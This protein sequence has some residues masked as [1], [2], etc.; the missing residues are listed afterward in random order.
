MEERT[1]WGSSRQPHYALLVARR[2]CSCDVPGLKKIILFLY[3]LVL[4]LLPLTFLGLL[5]FETFRIIVDG[6]VETRVIHDC[7]KGLLLSWLADGSGS[8]HTP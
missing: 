4:L 5:I 8:W 1:Y 6:G 7:D 3:I 2:L